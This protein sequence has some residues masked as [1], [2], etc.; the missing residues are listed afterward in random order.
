MHVVRSLSDMWVSMAF[1]RGSY[2]LCVRDGMLQWYTVQCTVVVLQ[3]RRKYHPIPG[4][5]WRC[6]SDQI[7]L[8][9]DSCKLNQV[10]PYLQRVFVAS[11]S[12]F[13]LLRVALWSASNFLHFPCQVKLIDWQSDKDFTNI[14]GIHSPESEPNLTYNGFHFTRFWWLK[15]L[16]E[17]SK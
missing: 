15:R 4:W 14:R 12:F 10:Q 3:L 6:E 16:D 17:F 1:G 9:T 11:K 13:L 5:P 2:W 8:L 7:R